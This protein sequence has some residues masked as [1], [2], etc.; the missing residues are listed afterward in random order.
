MKATLLAA[1]QA[2]NS[3]ITRRGYSANALVFG[4]QSNF[5]D[6][7][8]DEA[9]TS[10]TLGQALSIDSEVAKQAE[11]RAAAKRALLHTDAQQKIKKALMRKPGTETKEYLPGEKV[12]FWVPGAKKVRY[13][14][15]DGVWRGPAIRPSSSEE[16]MD[17]TQAFKELQ[18]FEDEALSKRE[19]EELEKTEESRPEEKRWTADETRIKRTRFGRTK[20]EAQQL[21]KGLKSMKR[22]KK[23]PFMKRKYVK[24]SKVKKDRRRSVPVDSEASPSIAPLDEDIAEAAEPEEVAEVVRGEQQSQIAREEEEAIDEKLRR[25]GRDSL[26]MFQCVSREG[27]MMRLEWKPR[28]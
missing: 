1:I 10:T 6:V 11:L 19:Y 18:Q 12:H 23:E 9:H 3:T 22:V 17:A 28:I 20:R 21:M 25:E 26:T 7:L 24:K 27:D 14:R 16:A 15:D 8:D 2:K 5:P 4:K 13:R